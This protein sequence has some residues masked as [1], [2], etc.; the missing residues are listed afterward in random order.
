MTSPS[1]APRAVA[2]LL[3]EIIDDAAMFP[4]ASMDLPEAV[5]AHVAAQTGDYRWML[6]RFLCPAARVGELPP[7][8]SLRLGVVFGEWPEHAVEAD[9]VDAV[10]ARLPDA[11]VATRAEELVRIANGAR[12]WL[13]IP[14]AEF[15]SSEW[16]SAAKAIAAVD[17]CGLKVRCGGEHAGAFPP[18]A[19]LG[20]IVAACRDAGTPLKATAGL[21]HPFRHPDAAIGVVMH[22]FVNVAVA[23]VLARH[24]ALDEGDIAAVLSEDD[25][26]AFTLGGDGVGWRDRVVGA[27][28]VAETR[29]SG[30]FAGFGSCS[31]REPVE[32]LVA[33]GVLS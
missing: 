8:V 25:P 30:A 18:A 14:W 17:G 33:L 24:A 20:S 19:L 9:T 7:G 28:E 10:E 4:P 21:H 31:F 29:A 5:D 16:P 26:D 15:P 2:A 22:G 12:A 3:A 6:G 27:D 32:D 11:D 1:H 13:E 23:V